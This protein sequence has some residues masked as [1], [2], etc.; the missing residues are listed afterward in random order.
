VFYVQCLASISPVTLSQWQYPDG[1]Q[2]VLFPVNKYSHFIH[3]T[4]T[5]MCTDIFLNNESE[6]SETS[7]QIWHKWVLR[8]HQ[9]LDLWKLDGICWIRIRWIR[10]WT[11]H[12]PSNRIQSYGLTHV[13]VSP[14][15][16][17]YSKG[18]VQDLW[19]YI[20]GQASTTYGTL[21]SV[22]TQESDRLT[23]KHTH[24]YLSSILFSFLFTTQRYQLLSTKMTYGMKLSHTALFKGR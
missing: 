1:R 4:H 23:M 7:I 10:M 22:H 16:W 2:S 24:Y 8:I 19:L 20:K 15:T 18:Q 13:T 9:I 14:A 11:S 5:Q 6:Q 3:S 21:Y 12:I 17:V